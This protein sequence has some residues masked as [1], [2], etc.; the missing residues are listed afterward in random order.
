MMMDEPTILDTLDQ[1]DFF[2]LAQLKAR[3]GLEIKGM[4]GHGRS[5]YAQAKDRYDLRGSRANVLKHLELMV[6][7][8]LN[9]L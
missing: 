4:K 3:L 2:V 9:A 1:I 8:R 7:E 5:A 6:E